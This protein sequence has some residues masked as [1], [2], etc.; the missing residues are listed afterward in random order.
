MGAGICHVLLAASNDVT[1]IEETPAKAAAARVRIEQSLQVAHDKGLLGQV[2]QT[3]MTGL[4][5]GVDMSPLAPAS[6][7]I[8]CVPESLELK[9]EVLT[10][11]EAVT[12][13]DTVIASNTSALSIDDL[14]GALESPDRFVGMHFFNP[15]PASGLVEIVRGAS[16]A[17]DTLRAAHQLAQRLGKETIEV[18]DSPGFATS[19]L[20]VLLGLEAIR[21]V[22]S[23]VATVE[24]IDRAMVL[25]YRHPMGPLRLS[26]LV[27]LD[28]RLAIAESLALRLGPRFEPPS[29]LRRM[30]ANGQ[31]GKKTGQ[32]FYT[33]P[34]GSTRT[35]GQPPG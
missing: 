13:S 15:V 14:A 27:G 26:D 6:V 18:A 28:V 3:A 21:M 24:D 19:R 25:G 4:E 34:Q 8:E 32:G 5:T 1:L 35:P 30:V 9:R 29:L 11:I 23:G 7:V 16:T 17:P 12:S 10:A 2:P 33:W 20:G 22:E 31:L